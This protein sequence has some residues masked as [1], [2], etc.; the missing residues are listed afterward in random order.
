MGFVEKIETLLNGL[1]IKLGELIW[2]VVPGRLKMFF[3]LLQW[4][5][6][7]A[8]T[9]IKS[10]PVLLLSIVR[11][12]FSH[13]A[14]KSKTIDFKGILTDTYKR[15]SQKYESKTEN[16]LLRLLLLPFGLVSDWL[17]G[18]SSTQALVLLLFTGGSLLS[19]IGI[20]FSGQRLL[21]ATD[22]SRSPASAEEI[23]Y[24]RPAYY[25]KERR[26]LNLS[27]IRLP[28]YVADIN[29]IKSVDIDITATI[30]NRYSRNFLEKSELILRDHLILHIEPSVASFPIEDEGKEIIR[31]KF[32]AEINAFLQQHQVE[33]EVEELKIVY[34]LAN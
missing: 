3:S 19:M 31:K 28:V 29:E 22:A 1:L 24:D 6:Q 32:W 2:K 26:H 5:K 10:S 25:K 27:N 16:K 12:V 34:V 8:I 11:K 21:K 9:F 17:S 7:K 23:T 30:S 4:W 14:A 18:L 20:G 15:A 33:G 13:L